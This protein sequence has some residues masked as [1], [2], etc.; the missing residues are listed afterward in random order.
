MCASC[1]VAT[2]TLRPRVVCSKRTGIQYLGHQEL[3]VGEVSLLI[4]FCATK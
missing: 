3:I 2:K 4:F 1:T